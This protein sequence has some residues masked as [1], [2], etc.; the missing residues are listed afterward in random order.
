MPLADLTA[1]ANL[2]LDHLGEPYLTDYETDTGTT[3]AA[4][5]L[6]LPQCIETVLEGHAWSFATRTLNLLPSPSVDVITVTGTLTDGTDPVTI[7]PLYE[8]ENVVFPDPFVGNARYFTNTG[9]ISDDLTPPSSGTFYLAGIAHITS[10]SVFNSASINKYEDG[11]LVAVWDIPSG[12][13]LGIYDPSLLDWTG[14]AGL[15]STGDPTVTL[16]RNQIPPG[17][18]TSWT[19]P[20]DCLRLRQIN[21]IDID[22]P[23]LRFEIQGRQLLLSDLYTETDP[24][25]VTYIT[26]DPPVDEWPTTFTDAVAFLLASR[27]APKLTQ[28]QTIADSMFQKHEIALGKARSKDTRETRSAENNTPRM[29]AAKSGLVQSRYGRTSRPPY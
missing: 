13:P 4:V 19:L 25:A 23:E 11:N 26:N 17:W 3:A 7:P 1:V 28:S 16:T 12:V 27:L 29:L 10:P 2:A 9:E 15:T 14:S 6:H 22:Q 18:S 5:R 8:V 24:P 20:T 21:S